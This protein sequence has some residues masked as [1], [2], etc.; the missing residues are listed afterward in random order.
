MYFLYN[1]LTSINSKI[2]FMIFKAIE[3]NKIENLLWC[4]SNISTK[5]KPNYY[6]KLVINILYVLHNI[7]NYVRY[8]FLQTWEENNWYLLCHYQHLPL[9]PVLQPQLCLL[10][11]C[12]GLWSTKLTQK[13]PNN[14][15]VTTDI[16]MHYHKFSLAEWNG[17]LSQLFGS[18]ETSQISVDERKHCLFISMVSPLLSSA[19]E[20]HHWA[21]SVSTLQLHETTVKCRGI[22]LI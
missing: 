10:A 6:V 8:Y 4:K 18:M 3:C 19:E 9:L 12:T 21:T 7:S 20:Q 5:F 1:F 14:R 17:T 16:S 15:C 22:P 13:T 11:P 2:S